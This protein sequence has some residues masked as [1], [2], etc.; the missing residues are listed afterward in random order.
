M[1]GQ[2]YTAQERNFFN[3][4][5]QGHFAIIG[6]DARI[7]FTTVSIPAGLFPHPANVPVYG[8]F[9][10]RVAMLAAYAAATIPLANMQ[11]A[12]G[13]AGIVYNMILTVDVVVNNEHHQIQ[14]SY[15][16]AAI[17]PNHTQR[18]RFVALYRVLRVAATRRLQREFE[19]ITE[20]GSDFIMDGFANVHSVTLTVSDMRGIAQG[21]AVNGAALNRRGERNRQDRQR[22]RRRRVGGCNSKQQVVFIDMSPWS[23]NDRWKV[24][25]PSSS[26]NNCLIQV[27]KMGVR[28]LLPSCPDS[29]Q[30]KKM[31]QR[32]RYLT[33]KNKNNAAGARVDAVEVEEIKRD[34][35]KE[36]NRTKTEWL[37]REKE[38]RPYF[39][40]LRERLT[41][42]NQR[43]RKDVV[44]LASNEMMG[45]Q[46]VAQL[47]NFFNIS[48]RLFIK[49]GAKEDEHVGRYLLHPRSTSIVK[50]LLVDG[51]YFLVQSSD[52]KEDGQRAR[53]K[54][55]FTCKKCGMSTKKMN[56]K[57][58]Y[59][60]VC[61]ESVAVDNARL[62]R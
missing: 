46:H 30:W 55:E 34:M 52:V 43:I 44:M 62:M 54:E 7:G 18:Q 35:K 2:A 4:V 47:S 23:G 45:S 56:G 32:V 42:S 26:M 25:S 19:Q 11:G 21:P 13:N 61:S 8:V 28:Q 5:M 58:K 49:T 1:M 24:L 12:L 20:L 57:G 10:R 39:T 14:I 27:F 51:H 3:N 38:E 37:Q 22:A 31:R 60:H 29:E 9:R 40:F 59:A 48:V 6:R 33:R 50:I 15:P 53:I 36:K 41:W 16:Q 17:D